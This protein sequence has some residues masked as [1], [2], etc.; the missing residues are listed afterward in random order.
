MCLK[1]LGI[2]QLYYRYYWYRLHLK[3]GNEQGR[4]KNKY[5]WVCLK[6]AYSPTN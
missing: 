5:I 3:I 4:L 1:L 2:I 6:F